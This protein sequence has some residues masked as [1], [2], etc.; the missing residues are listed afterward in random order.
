MAI[1]NPLNTLINSSTD[2]IS[3]KEF[4]DS[5][6]QLSGEKNPSVHVCLRIPNIRQQQIR[7]L[8]GSNEHLLKCNL[9]T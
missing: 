8:K 9:N 6:S 2:L 5:P 1:P 4:S 3:E 7:N